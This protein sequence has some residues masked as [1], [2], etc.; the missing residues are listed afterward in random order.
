MPLTHSLIVTNSFFILSWFTQLQELTVIFSFIAN[1]KQTSKNT[2]QTRSFKLME[3]GIMLGSVSTS[4]WPFISSPFSALP[5]EIQFSSPSL[6]PMVLI[7]QCFPP[8]SNIDFFFFIHFLSYPNQ[9]YLLNSF[10][11]KCLHKKLW[12]ST[13]KN[14]Y[15]SWISR[16]QWFNREVKMPTKS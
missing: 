8:L 2:K 3:L 1:K 10:W 15:W 13:K 6:I 12:G 16:N 7:A 11:S 5:S 4:T 14:G 9:K